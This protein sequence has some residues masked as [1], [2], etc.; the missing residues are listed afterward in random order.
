MLIYLFTLKTFKMSEINDFFKSYQRLICIHT[1]GSTF[2][3]KGCI[4]TMS[5]LDCNGALIPY[6]YESWKDENSD[7]RDRLSKYFYIYSSLMIFLKDTLSFIKYHFTE[8]QG[9]LSSTRTSPSI[10][11][12]GSAS[13]GHEDRQFVVLTSEKQAR[14]VALPSQNSVYK[15]PLVTET[16]IVIKAEITSLKGNHSFFL[17]LF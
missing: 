13:D 15:Q 5:F 2:K 9:K 12:Q 3:L 14:V 6:S 1:D 7:G 11:S 16:N 10:N 4:L 17:F 8:N